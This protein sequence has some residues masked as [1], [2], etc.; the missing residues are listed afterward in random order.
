MTRIDSARAAA[1]SAR[2][3]VRH[4]AEAA[5][6]YAENAKETAT[7]YA[8]EAGARLGPRVSEA[9]RLTRCSAREGYDN[10]VAPRLSRA[11]DALPPEVDQTAHRAA[12]R[13]RQAA[14]EAT[15]YAA[16]RLDA[17]L[18]AAGPA[19]DEARSRSTAALAALRGRVSADEVERLVARRRRC[20]RAGRLAKRLAVVGLLAGGAYAAWRWWD[21]Q[22]NPDWLVEPPQATELADGPGP[23]PSP[24]TE[25]S[26]SGEDR[27]S[28]PEG[29]SR[30]DE[31]DAERPEGPR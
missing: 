3:S 9:A 31:S 24:G 12:R 5:A 11:W 23:S 26:R 21:R 8:H 17:A 1:D 25:H 27:T 2:E 19:R 28:G 18:S 22:A 10:H 7:H 13:T 14:R 16:P 6:P 29:T 4:A 30:D 20:D 15:D